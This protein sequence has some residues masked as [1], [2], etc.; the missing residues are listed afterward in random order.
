MIN[1]DTEAP[2]IT[3]QTKL[4]TLSVIF[5]LSSCVMLLTLNTRRLALNIKKKKLDI[6]ETGSV[7]TGLTGE[8]EILVS[9]YNKCP[10]P[11]KVTPMVRRKLSRITSM[12]QK[13]MSSEVNEVKSMSRTIFS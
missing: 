8:S 5:F 11:L 12:A 2:L 4:I 1:S 6:P 7:Q 13:Q 10:R 9:K 3:S